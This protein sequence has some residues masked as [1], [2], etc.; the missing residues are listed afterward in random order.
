MKHQ[1]F[2][3][4]FHL[5]QCI[6]KTFLVCCIPKDMMSYISKHKCY[7]FNATNLDILAN[8]NASCKQNE[9]EYNGLG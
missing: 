4:D 8:E 5:A 3:K 2:L 6:F 1:A 9:L 7:D